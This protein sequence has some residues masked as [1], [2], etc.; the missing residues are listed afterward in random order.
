MNAGARRLAETLMLPSLTSKQELDEF[1]MN[2]K[3]GLEELVKETV[4]W[5]KPS[6]FAKT[7][8]NIDCRRATDK[9]TRLRTEYKRGRNPRTEAALQ[10][11]Q[12]AK[13]KTIKKARTLDFRRAVH[14][15]A[16]SSKGIWSLAKWGRERS[17]LPRQIPKFPV[18]KKKTQE[19]VAETFEEK[20]TVLRDTFFPPP[21]EADLTDIETMNYPP[22]IPMKDLVSEEE[23]VRA[24]MRSKPDKAPGINGIPNRFLRMVLKEL[25]TT[26]TNLFRACLKLGYHPREFKKAN[27]IVLRKPKKEDYTEPKSYRP[28]ALLDTMG[29]ALEGIVAKRLSDYA[30]NGN[31]L[32]VEQMG[33]RRGRSTETAL[34]TIVE[35]IH[36]V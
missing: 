12:R 14:E 10:E 34:E 21:P 18:L 11:A 35:T 36:T 1:L 6:K 16:E 4:P 32:P 30:E 17:M 29:K 31:M 28:I 7:F 13:G 9:V 25:K 2:I 15:A 8:W 33:A 24:V 3:K 5:A 23:V 22:P 27:T 19:E 20:V 26:I